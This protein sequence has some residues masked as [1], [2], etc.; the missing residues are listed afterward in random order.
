VST[1]LRE[2]FLDRWARY[3]PG[4]ELPIAFFYSTEPGDAEKVPPAGSHHC[5]FA[6]IHRVRRGES[7]AFR[8][9]SLACFGGKRYLGFS[10]AIRPDFEYFLS[11]GIPGKLEGERYKKTPEIV[12]EM[13]KTRTPFTAPR[14]WIVFKR[15]DRLDEHDE[16]EVIIFFATPDALAGLFTLA[17]YEEIEPDGVIAP[18]SSGC[19][20]IVSHPYLQRSAPRPRAVLGLFDPSARPF[21]AR[22]LLTF[23]VPMPKF[24]RMVANMDQSFLITGTWEVMRRRLAKSQDAE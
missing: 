11:C 12:R 16:P 24:E 17:N 4:A 22:D 6:D 19:G 20:S 14:A 8:G 7:L 15:W 18:M 23:A 21:V 5:V 10:Q 13:E 2:Q 1:T 9:E 3:F